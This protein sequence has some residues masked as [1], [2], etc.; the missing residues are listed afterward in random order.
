MRSASTDSGVRSER[1][2]A[3]ACQLALEQFRFRRL[4]VV[5]DPDNIGS[6]RVALRNGFSEIGARDGRVLHIK[7]LAAR[8]S[9]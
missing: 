9:E 2:V 4:E 3:L 8:G 1:R 6:R 7:Y 5:T